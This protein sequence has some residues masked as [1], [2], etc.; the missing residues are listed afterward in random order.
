MA[1][2]AKLANMIYSKG[3]FKGFSPAFGS[4]IDE[5]ARKCF[6]HLPVVN[7]RTG[8]K[9][10]KQ[11]PIGPMMMNYYLPD[12]T[13]SIHN[14]VPDFKTDIMQRREEKLARLKRRGKGPPKKGQGKRALKNNKKK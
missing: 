4:L 3:K 12:M 2:A 14:T 1:E 9:L 10:L 11:K 5:A 8:F 7:H 13:K 6:G